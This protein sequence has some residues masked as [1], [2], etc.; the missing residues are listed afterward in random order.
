[1]ER[2]APPIGYDRR[3][4]SFGDIY[5]RRP[6]RDD[7]SH[8]YDRNDM[9]GGVGSMDRGGLERGGMDRGGMDRGGMDRGGIDRGSMDRGGM[10]RGGMGGMDRGG[11]DRFQP[12]G[13]SP[14]PPR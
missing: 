12:R 3:E 2:R 8:S 13:R 7:M 1:M 11:M 10:E 9:Y 5:A 4:D 6:E 14:P